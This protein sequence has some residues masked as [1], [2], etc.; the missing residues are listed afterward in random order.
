MNIARDED[1]GQR[2][3][4]VVIVSYNRLEQLKMGIEAVL[5]EP[6]CG[7]VVVDNGSTDGSREWLATS[8]DARLRVLT[9]ERNLGGAGGFEVGFQEAL[10]A[11]SP[12]WIVCFDDD[13]RPQ[14]G[15]LG[16]FLE[17]DLEGADSAA[18]AVYYPD[19][20]IC[21]MNR[22]SWNPFWHPIKLLKTMFGIL[23]GKA[24]Q[25]FHLPDAA[26]EANSATSIDSSSFVGCFVSREW[27][28]KI[29]LPRGDLF[30]YGD[31]IIYTLMLS[32]QGAKHFFLPDITF[33][34]DCST[35]SSQKVTYSP[36][37]KA[38]Y[39]Y[40][41][42][43]LIYRLAAG[44]WFPFVVITKTLMW[45]SA[46][47]RYS[48]KKSYLTLCGVAVRDGVLGKTGRTHDEITQRFY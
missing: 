23:T 1:D 7:V 40:R 3:L 31:D 5:N 39:T 32:R 38:Y 16:R 29:G 14:P 11:F 4:A 47:L 44:P 25:G 30:I 8:E 10:S 9:P 13:A 34:H 33:T 37:W 46:T 27:I 22:P 42:G 6:V 28:E 45:V 43:L 20:R 21:E 48:D 15:A 36:L 26:Y 2:T 24:R 41:N 35:F 17:R 18:G 12:D 19:G